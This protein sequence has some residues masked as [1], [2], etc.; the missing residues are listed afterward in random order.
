MLR[1]FLCAAVVVA[2]TADVGRSADKDGKEVK[3]TIKKIDAEKGVITVTV[4]VKKESMDKEFTI[5]DKTKFTIMEGD[6]KKEMTGKDGIK[7]LK[8]GAAV[9]LTA[10]GDKV[11]EIK[12][13]GKKK[14]TT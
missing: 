13:G 1:A 10:D 6:D 14:K 4:K 3:G 5:T 12:V 8:E 2:L 9:A 11:T 7:G